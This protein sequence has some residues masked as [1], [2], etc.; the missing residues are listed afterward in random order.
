MNVQTLGVHESVSTVF[1]PG[2]L[3][4][5]L[6]DADPEITVVGDD[7]RDLDADPP[8][9]ADCDA[10]VTFEHRDAFLEH[11]G[12]VHSIQAG[13]DRFPLNEF[14][15][16]EVALTNSAGIHATSVGQTVA[17][18]LLAF[19]RRL[20]VHRDGQRAREWRPPAW[21][22]AFTLDGES[23]CVVG[24]GTLGRGIAAH[25][26]ALGM[27]VTGVRS[28]GEPVQAVEEVY[29]PDQLREAISDVRFV[30]VAV[31]LTD[32]TRRLIGPDELA[33]MREDAYLIN[34]AR[35][36]VVDQDALVETLEAGTIEGAALDVFEEEPLPPKSPLWEFEE[37]IVS[38]HCAAFTRDYFRDVA[39]LVRESLA[40][41]E[42]DEELYNRVV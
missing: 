40:R 21:D 25:A 11:V 12:W 39:D 1:P 33:A 32:E 35:G 37:V 30:A 13:V 26:A 15:A 27:D 29:T 6:R 8:S 34:V 7:P 20:H 2:E 22:E 23:I 3:Q 9:L 28:S 41:I 24:L 10:V 5:E 19:A 36:P 42:Q 16:A 31:P 4:R 18:F 14:E 17:G 38:P